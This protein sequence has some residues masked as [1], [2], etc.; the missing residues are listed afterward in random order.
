MWTKSKLHQLCLNALIVASETISMLGSS[1]KTE[2]VDND[3]VNTSTK[4]DHAVS[5]A[6]CKFFQES[7]IPADLYSEEL[8]IINTKNPQFI[9]MWDDIDGTENWRRSNGTMP[10]CTIIS[11]FDASGLF[12]HCLVTVLKEYNSGLIW[13]AVQGQGCWLGQEKCQTSHC[14]E[15]TKKTAVRLDMYEMSDLPFLAPLNKKTWVKD[16][17]STGYHCAAV[18]SGIADAF[19]GKSCKSYEIGVAFLVIEAGGFVSDW[20]GNSYSNVVLE[21]NGKYPVVCAATEEL[22]KKILKE[23]N[24]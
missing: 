12:G 8:G 3:A 7:G 15:L 4:A 16:A 23:I 21:F 13:S 11:I 20:Q 1:G 10:C 9:I 22:G 5:E 19:V 18:S 14:V 17:G 6:L 24:Q 2:V